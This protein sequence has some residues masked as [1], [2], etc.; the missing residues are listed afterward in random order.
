MREEDFKVGDKIETHSGDVMEVYMEINSDGI[1]YKALRTFPYIP[2]RGSY[3]GA[4][5]FYLQ[6]LWGGVKKKL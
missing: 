2:Y 1:E 4:L 5:R 6:G 3:N